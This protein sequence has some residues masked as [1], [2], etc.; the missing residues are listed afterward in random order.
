[1]NMDEPTKPSSCLRCGKTE[2]ASAQGATFTA[3]GDNGMV[4]TFWMCEPCAIDCSPG[5][6]PITLKDPTLR[7][8]PV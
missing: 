7:V 1:M 2:S 8:R 4:L 5:Q 3:T 6:G